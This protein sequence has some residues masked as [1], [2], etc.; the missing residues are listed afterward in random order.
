LTILRGFQ[1]KSNKK[2]GVM[3]RLFFVILS[4]LLVSSLAA[5]EKGTV[6]MG[7]MIS[8]NSYKID[9]DAD[10]VNTFMVMP[11]GGYFITD[12]IM[13]EA[14][15]AYNHE[16]SDSY[17]DPYNGFGF[18]LGG[19]YFYNNI[20]GGVGFKITSEDNGVT[21]YSAK[22]LQFKGGYL[23]NIAKNV[24][25]DLGAVYDMGIGEYGG[26]LEDFDNEQSDFTIGLGIEVF[27]ERI[28]SFF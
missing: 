16:N 28:G 15:L 26:D 9:S 19:R 6:N 1:N 24:Y 22:Y 17:E 27:L 4:I 20:Y 3:K 23:F 10:A 11:Y 21:D 13:A 5:F 12:N 2:G 7:G 18:G 25:L 8:F 14:I